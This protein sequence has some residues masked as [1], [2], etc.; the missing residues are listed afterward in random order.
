MIILTSHRSGSTFFSQLFNQRPDV[1][2]MFEPLIRFGHGCEEIDDELRV[3]YLSQLFECDVQDQ[4]IINA[5][6]GSKKFSD[7]VSIEKC[8]RENFCFR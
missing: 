8:K 1:F 7:I 6:G 5:Y 4:G 3:E 2:F